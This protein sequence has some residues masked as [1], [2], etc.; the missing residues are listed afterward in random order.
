M[1]T[2][3]SNV[4]RLLSGI[5]TWKHSDLSLPSNLAYFVSSLSFMKIMWNL[6]RGC[7]Y[8][9]VVGIL[10]VWHKKHHWNHLETI[11]R[12]LNIPEC[13]KRTEERGFKYCA[14][15]LQV[16]W[17]QNTFLPTVRKNILFCTFSWSLSSLN[18]FCP[19][20][21]FLLSAG[22]LHF[23]SSLFWQLEKL[24]SNQL[25]SQMTSGSCFIHLKSF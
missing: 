22:Y 24:L 3:R 9:R 17:T 11:Y 10:H 2:L 7:V 18:S 23:L 16:Y 15:W 13:N 8:E 20:S 14:V 21:C 6:V 19:L 5:L 12:N 1:L 25:F 4:D